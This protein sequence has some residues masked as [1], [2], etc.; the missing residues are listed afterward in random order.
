MIIIAIIIMIVIILII[1]II[2]FPPK[3]WNSRLTSGVGLSH[4]L[5]AGEVLFSLGWKTSKDGDGVLIKTAVVLWPKT[6]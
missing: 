1:S 3:P 2:V 5:R 6:H 4:V